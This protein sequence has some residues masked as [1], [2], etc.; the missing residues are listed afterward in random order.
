MLSKFFSSFA[1]RSSMFLHCRFL[2]Y[3][4]NLWLMAIDALRSPLFLRSFWSETGV[5][6]IHLRS[7]YENRKAC[8]SAPR[9]VAAFAEPRKMR[10]VFCCDENK[11]VRALGTTLMRALQV[12]EVGR[13]MLLTRIRAFQSKACEMVHHALCRLETTTYCMYCMSSMQSNIQRSSIDACCT[14]T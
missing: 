8:F 11:W 14:K 13:N 2:P 5:E 12:R 6:Q 9:I 1:T 7:S 3:S 4:T 10:A